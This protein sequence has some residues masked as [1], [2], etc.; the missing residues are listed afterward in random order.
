MQEDVL[1]RYSLQMNLIRY[2]LFIFAYTLVN[3]AIREEQTSQF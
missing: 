1:R 3:S 2:V